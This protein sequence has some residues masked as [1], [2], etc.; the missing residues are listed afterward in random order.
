MPFWKCQTCGFEF[1]Q[2]KEPE[3]CIAC[4]RQ[5]RKTKG[6]EQLP[7]AVPEP[8]ELPADYHWRCKTCGYRSVTKA[9]LKKCPN[10]ER[11]ERLSEGFEPL[12]AAA[13]L[14]LADARMKAKQ[15]EERASIPKPTAYA[16]KADMIAW[17]LS[18][19]VETIE[20]D[21]TVLRLDECENK[22][23]PTKADLMN[24]IEKLLAKEHAEDG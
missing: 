23:P 12:S 4:D 18:R 1:R 5:D 15:A 9:I 2:A 24:I 16:P 21:G 22:Y 17:L 19:G 10:C 14:L 11:Q 7:D 6:F 13:R 8:T 20:V 3:N